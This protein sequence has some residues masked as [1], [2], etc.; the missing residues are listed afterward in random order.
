MLTPHSYQGGCQ[1]VTEAIKVNA[2]RG[3]VYAAMTGGQSRSLTRLLIGA[4]RLSL[5][6]LAVFDRWGRR[7]NRQGI[8]IIATDFVSMSGIKDVSAPLRLNGRA[9]TACILAVDAGLESYRKH[10]RAA[11][12]GADFRQVA[13]RSHVILERVHRDEEQSGSLFPM[14]R[15]MLESI[16]NIAL[17]SI[18]YAEQSGG[19]TLR[20]SKAFIRFHVAGLRLAIPIDRKAQ[21]CHVLGAGIIENDVPPIPFEEAWR[22]HSGLR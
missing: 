17:R 19:K 21:A 1:H 6:P 4:E 9:D 5:L 20:L 12:K 16:G 8:P 10:V 7:Y 15:H 18:G 13:A 22:H 2:S 11:I 14:T 3:P